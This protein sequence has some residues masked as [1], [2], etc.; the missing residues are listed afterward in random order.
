MG[1]RLAPCAGEYA[2]LEESAEGV[3]PAA[4]YDC[5]RIPSKPSVDDMGNGWG[6]ICAMMATLL[7]PHAREDAA[8]RDTFTPSIR[9]QRKRRELLALPSPE[10]LSP[11]KQP[12]GA[13]VSLR[14]NSWLP[15][16]F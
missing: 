13:G 4:S 5:W 7:D 1:E 3:R 11:W 6:V 15:Y 2:A 16:S 9:F 8:C 12:S 10:A 14:P